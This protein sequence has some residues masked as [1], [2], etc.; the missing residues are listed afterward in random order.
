[1]DDRPVSCSASRQA[2]EYTLDTQAQDLAGLAMSVEFV[3]VVLDARDVAKAMAYVTQKEGA[4]PASAGNT[5]V[6]IGDTLASGD[7]D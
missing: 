1:M 7:F 6:L 2:A 3:I 5:T 4:V